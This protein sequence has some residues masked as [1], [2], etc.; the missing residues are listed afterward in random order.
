MFNCAYINTSRRLGYIGANGS[1]TW[2]ETGV[3]RGDSQIN[4]IRDTYHCYLN[5]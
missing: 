2:E 5:D 1:L 4:G 3:P